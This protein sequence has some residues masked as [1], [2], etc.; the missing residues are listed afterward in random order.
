MIR[1]PPRSTRTDTLFPYTTLFR[2]VDKAAD[3][4][5]RA[6]AISAAENLVVRAGF[7]AHRGARDLE[8]RREH[9]VWQ[10][11]GDRQ[12]VTPARIGG[13]EHPALGQ[14]ETRSEAHTSETP[15]PNAHPVCRLLLEKH[16]YHVNYQST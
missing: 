8:E 2:S 9:V 14:C 16:K 12:R 3:A 6:A 13:V 5:R 1:R 4:P 11:V 7:A 15:V 10:P